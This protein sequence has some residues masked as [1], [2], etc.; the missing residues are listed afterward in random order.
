M[1]P[2]IVLECSKIFNA[3]RATKAGGNEEDR[4]L[5][6]LLSYIM[7]S[8]ARSCS[9][10]FQDLWVCYELKEKRNGWFVEFG[11]CNGRIL[12]NSL[13]LEKRFG[14]SGVIAEPSPMWRDAI[15]DGFRTCN[16]STKCVFTESGKT[17]EFNETP[18]GELSTISSYSSSDFHKDHR[19]LG[20]KVLVETISLLDL[21][22]ESNA[23]RDIEYLSIDTEGSEFDILN[24][25]DFDEF[26]FKLITVEHNGTERRKDIF[27]LLTSK[28]YRRKFVEFSRWDDWY[29]RAC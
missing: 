5:L 1:H 20:H 28:G 8:P 21:L 19:A 4:D 6:G 26:S 15:L 16:V 11:A 24:A 10:L 18:I 23:P 29:V 3:I 12:S 25:H 9:Q 22:R 17:L 27:D 2:G 7:R 13:L 14:W